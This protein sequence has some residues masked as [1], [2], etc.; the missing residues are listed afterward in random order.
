M[1]C[2]ITCIDYREKYMSAFGGL[3]AI[4]ETFDLI[5][6]ITD[7]T[8]LERKDFAFNDGI[9]GGHIIKIDNLHDL[10]RVLERKKPHV[11][12]IFRPRQ[13]PVMKQV[14]QLVQQYSNKWG[15]LENKLMLRN[16][17]TL[18]NPLKW[19][20]FFA[21]KY[22]LARLLL[23][24]RPDFFMTNN[25]MVNAR[26]FWHINPKKVLYVPHM[27]AA[28]DKPD[29]IAEKNGLFMDQYL[30]FHDEIETVYGIKIKPS[31]YYSAL[32]A[33][34]HEAKKTYGLD[35]II[36]ARH[37]NSRGEELKWL[38]DFE[39]V[40]GQSRIQAKKASMIFGHYSNSLLYAIQYSKPLILLR[41]PFLQGPLD[42]LLIERARQ[43]GAQIDTF[44]G[45]RVMQN[46]RHC[47]KRPLMSFLY[48][49]M[50]FQNKALDACAHVKKITL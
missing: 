45:G 19:F 26:L 12:L 15:V 5:L 49:H 17:F 25:Q 35:K 50:Y 9:R 33:Y 37:P 42:D 44:E 4:N 28:C 38:D 29:E 14:F 7:L 11:S 27:D 23:L 39:C 46:K 48:N 31:S 1:K 21:L 40:S 20:R 2:L 43:T 6:D 30:P 22:G 36:I 16:P 41:G 18:L 47:I 13:G 32:N 34:L 10:A 3:D 8:V 24:P